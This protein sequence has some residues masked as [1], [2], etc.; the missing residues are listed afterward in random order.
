[1][2]SP[3][4]EVFKIYERDE[5]KTAHDLFA[6]TYFENKYNRDINDVWIKYK[7]LHPEYSGVGL[8]PKDIL[9]NFFGFVNYEF[10]DKLKITGPNY[11]MAGLRVTDKQILIVDELIR[12]NKDSREALTLLLQ[13]DFKEQK[14]SFR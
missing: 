13:E 6:A 4:G 7:K 11:S 12:L 2:I 5:M 9:I 14:T 10:F 3:E 1:M 8:G